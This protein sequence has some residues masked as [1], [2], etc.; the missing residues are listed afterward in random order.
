MHTSLNQSTQNTARCVFDKITQS[1]IEHQGTQ[2][3]MARS[4]LDSID[5]QA[6][7]DRA[8]ADSAEAASPE[9]I[10][11]ATSS[12]AMASV[13]GL[14]GAHFYRLHLR[15]LPQVISLLLLQLHLLRQESSESRD[16]LTRT[17]RRLVDLESGNTS[18]YSRLQQRIQEL[19]KQNAKY[20]AKYEEVRTL[21]L[22]LLRTYMI[23]NIEIIIIISLL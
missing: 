18:D 15:Q 14:V 8:A 7:L 23:A 9:L 3:H 20:K 10:K 16:H 6:A 12:R 19:M 21:T 17:R 11:I 5:V 4:L 13:Q 1:P 2:I 22:S